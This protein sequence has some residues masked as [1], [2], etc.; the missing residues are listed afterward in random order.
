MATGNGLNVITKNNIKSYN[1]TVNAINAFQKDNIRKLNLA[2]ANI[3]E[4][5]TKLA[6]TVG[7]LQ[8]SISSLQKQVFLNQVLIDN[9]EKN[10]PYSYDYTILD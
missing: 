4:P 9:W 6:K 7:I 10:P 5:I 1:T 3:E 8:S 2:L